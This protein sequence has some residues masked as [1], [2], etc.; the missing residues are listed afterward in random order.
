M[1]LWSRNSAESTSQVIS[2]SKTT[3]LAATGSQHEM[4]LS[5]DAEQDHASPANDLVF[6][7]TFP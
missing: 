3:V 1:C 5:I 2:T 4:F 6:A 7:G